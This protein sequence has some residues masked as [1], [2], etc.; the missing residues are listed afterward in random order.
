MNGLICQ[1]CGQALALA[2]A[3]CPACSTAVPVAQRLA[4][5]LPR[6]EGLAQDN[7]GMKVSGEPR[8]I[9]V[10][11]MQGRSL[12]LLGNSPLQLNGKVR[13]TFSGQTKTE[14]LIATLTPSS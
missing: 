4:V 7:P 2:D 10:N 3:K 1:H 6:A 13:A 11:G 12:E 14:E 8:N 5:L 9:D